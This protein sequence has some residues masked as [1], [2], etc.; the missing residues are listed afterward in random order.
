MSLLWDVV[1]WF[2]QRTNCAKKSSFEKVRQRSGRAFDREAIRPVEW[3][4]GP[5]KGSGLGG[6]GGGGILGVGALPFPTG[7]A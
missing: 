7:T 5:G 3:K 2:V 6:A 1:R 4:R